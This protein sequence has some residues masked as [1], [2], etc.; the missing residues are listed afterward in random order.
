MMRVTDVELDDKDVVE[1]F[2]TAME[3]GIGYW[4]IADEYR[5][6]Y[7]YEDWE[8][9]IVKP[10]DDDQVLVVL[11]D[12]EGEDFEN[13][14]LTPAKIKAGV[15]WMLNNGYQYNI[16]DIDADAADVIVQAGLFGKV[17]YA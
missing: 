17:V 7:L 12:A 5:W 15:K 8:N 14:E 11:S 6:L 4:S 2:T 10:L 13:L 3:G 9:D 1:I 16:F